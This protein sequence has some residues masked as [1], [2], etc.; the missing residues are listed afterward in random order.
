MG[1]KETYDMRGRQSLAFRL[2]CID[3]EALVHVL[4]YRIAVF[5]ALALAASIIL[6][7]LVVGTPYTNITRILLIA[8][9][10]LFTPQLFEAAKAASVIGSRGVVFGKLNESFKEYGAHKSALNPLYAIF[11]YVVFAVWLIGLVLAV[12]L[13][14]FGHP[15]LVLT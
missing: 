13:V 9:W 7:M 10:V 8:V 12:I 5:V 6:G 15:L 11:P 2:L 14:F 1:S 3:R 4:F